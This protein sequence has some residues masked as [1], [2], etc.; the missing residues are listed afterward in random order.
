MKDLAYLIGEWKT[1]GSITGEN[2]EINGT[3]SYEWIL[4]DKFILHKADVSVGN[5]QVQV[6][7]IIGISNS[8]GFDLR[9]FDNEGGFTEMSGHLDEKKVLHIKGDKMRAVLTMVDSNTLKAHWEKSS[10]NEEWAPWM[11]ITLERG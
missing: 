1:N 2:S 9:S 10:N 7:E 6:L 5:Q 3:D 4:D 11:D 8:G